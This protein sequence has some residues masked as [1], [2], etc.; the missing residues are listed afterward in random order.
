MGAEGTITTPFARI[1]VVGASLAGLRTVEALRRGGF[2]GQLTLVGEEPDAPYDRPPL[3]KEVLAGKL[4]P[5]AITLRRADSFDQLSVTLRLGSP[6]TGLDLDEGVIHVGSDR[7]PFDA[8]VIA[9]GCSAR[10]LPMMRELAGVHTIRTLSDAVRL[11]S[12]FATATRLVIIG[13]GFIGSEVASVARDAGIGVTVLEALEQPLM[14]ALGSEVGAVCG[15]LHRANGTDLRCGTQVAGLE[16][17]DRVTGV[18]LEGGEVVPAD[19]V[20]VAAGTVPGTG[21]LADSGLTI[22]D[23]VVCDAGLRAH[24]SH[25]FAL[26]DV[27]RWPNP[28]TGLSAR[29]EHWTNAGEQAMAVAR[30][31]LAGGDAVPHASVPYFWSDQ[32]GIRMQFVGA[33]QACDETR[34]VHRGPGHEV[35]AAYRSGPR[36]AGVFSIGLVRPVMRARALI[37]ARSDWTEAITKLEAAAASTPTTTGVA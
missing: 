27:A 1:V 26:G 24:G 32:Y 3:S 5:E 25:V 31:L 33:S 35:L 28:T 17:E 20:L 9:T 19:V 11:R 7:I 4:D 8:L 6:A 14:R 23:G 13:A 12:E 22:D 29:V 21:W 10:R 16:G 36:L 15:D 34:I 18:R 2:A 30:S 37:A